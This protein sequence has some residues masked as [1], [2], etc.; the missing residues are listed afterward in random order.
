M[1]SIGRKI[2]K[3]KCSGQ[4]YNASV[5]EMEDFYSEIY[6]VFTPQSASKYLQ[7]QFNDSSIL[8]H[9]IEFDEHYYKMDLDTFI[10]NSEQVY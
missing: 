6:G 5:D 8:I 4:K 7:K 3:S 2:V 1:R 9:N 10:K